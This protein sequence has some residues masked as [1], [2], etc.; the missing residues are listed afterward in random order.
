[1]LGAARLERLLQAGAGGKSELSRGRP[2]VTGPDRRPG[3]RGTDTR[4]RGSAVEVA[5]EVSVDK[6]CRKPSRANAEEVVRIICMIVN[7]AVRL[8]LVLRG[9]R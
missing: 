3:H 5:V 7:E 9:G 2:F 4:P 8:I 1:L 6:P